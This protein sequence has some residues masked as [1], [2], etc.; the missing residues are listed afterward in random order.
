MFHARFLPL[1]MLAYPIDINLISLRIVA[2]YCLS[3][4]PENTA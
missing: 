1:I 2:K 3:K 4:H